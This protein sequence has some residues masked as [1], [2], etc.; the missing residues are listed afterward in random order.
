[1]VRLAWLTA[2]LAFG[3][4]LTALGASAL[5]MPADV[6][7]WAAGVGTIVLGTGALA[8]GLGALVLSRKMAGNFADVLQRTDERLRTSTA[9]A[10][11][12]RAEMASIFEQ[13]TGTSR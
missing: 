4:G 11:R 5:L 8:A 6:R 7:A 13:A 3:A 9:R 10:E 2:S 1:M 12:D